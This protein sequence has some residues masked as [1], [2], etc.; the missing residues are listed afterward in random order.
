MINIAGGVSLRTQRDDVD[1]AEIASALGGGG[2]KKASGFGI[3]EDVRVAV[4][5]NIFQEESK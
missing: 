4:I 2:H 3:L 5:K 1:L